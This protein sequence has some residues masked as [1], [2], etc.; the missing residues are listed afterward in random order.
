VDTLLLEL[1]QTLD[2][3][4]YVVVSH[5]DHLCIRLPLAASVR[6]Y[7]SQGQV[8]LVPQFGP[9]SR[10][11][12]LLTT[13]AGASAV[14]GATVFTLGVTPLAFLAGFLG[15]VAVAHDAC[16]FVLTESCVTRLQ[17]L[18]VDLERAQPR[19]VLVDPGAAR[20]PSALSSAEAGT[21]SPAEHAGR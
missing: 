19:P 3:L 14:V 12:G 7:S 21:R 13:S 11:G 16:R 18:I 15:V 17:Q 2:R 4:G 20:L 8:R 6:V 9:F 1:R 5:G 10:T